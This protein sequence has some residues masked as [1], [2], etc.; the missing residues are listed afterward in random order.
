MSGSD[1]FPPHR[2]RI[3]TLEEANRL[4]ERVSELTSR[5][6]EELDRLRESYRTGESG[7][8]GD[9]ENEI[10]GVLDRWAREILQ[11]GAQPKGIFTVDFRSPDP[12]VLWCWAPEET[13]ITHRHF[14]WESF[15][16]RVQ[17]SAA[18][19]LWPARN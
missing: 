11:L 7:G 4:V 8:G 9:V 17:L 16:D 13:E 2:F 6:Q 19:S 15:K 12:N 14:T 10:R 18:D 5:T 1:R 3:F